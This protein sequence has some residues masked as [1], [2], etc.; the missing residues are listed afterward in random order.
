[1]LLPGPRS[2]SNW[3]S[4]WLVVCTAPGRIVA[5]YLCTA[6]TGHPDLPALFYIAMVDVPVIAG[7]FLR[8]QSPQG[9]L[10]VFQAAWAGLVAGC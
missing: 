3:P 10:I 7:K 4:T 5:G 6:V 2:A 8:H 1:M 9:Q